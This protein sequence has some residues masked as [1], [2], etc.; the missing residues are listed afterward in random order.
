MNIS[1]RVVSNKSKVDK[2]KTYPLDEAV[3]LLKDLDSANFDETVELHVNLGVNPRH[4]DQNIRGTVAYPHGTG[5]EVRVLVMTKSKAEEAKA[6]GADYVGLE[7]YVKKIEDGWTDVDIIIATPE[8]MKDVGKLGRILGPKGL[9]PNPKSGTVTQDVKAA[10]AEVKAGRT[11]FRVDKHGI[12]HLPVGKMS[13]SSNEIVDNVNTLMATLMRKRP[14]SL[15]G[16]YLQKI[17]LS[18]TMGP[19]IKVD[20]TT[21][22]K[23]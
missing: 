3:S 18:S 23:S 20:K 10:V 8:V 22:A 7:E 1:K 5:Q 2:T 11:E 6:A 12:I 17:T 15:K 13:F 16:T 9:M 19:G 4:A 21:V 14:L